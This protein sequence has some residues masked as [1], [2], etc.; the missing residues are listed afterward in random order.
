MI[1]L[2]LHYIHQVSKSNKVDDQIR[3]EIH[4]VLLHEL[5]HC[6]QHDAPE[7][8]EGSKGGLI[9]GLAD[10]IRLKSGLG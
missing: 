4:G 5:V 9:E 10:Y 1:R 2:S 7:S 3:K 6:V 8:R